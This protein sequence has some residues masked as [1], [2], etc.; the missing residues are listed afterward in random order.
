M[1]S[2]GDVG[3]HGNL[4]NLLVRDAADLGLNLGDE[5]SHRRHKHTLMTKNIH[6]KERGEKIKEIE[7]MGRGDQ[8]QR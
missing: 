1:Q 4:G 7:Q 6:A 8:T 3:C 5:S 2:Y